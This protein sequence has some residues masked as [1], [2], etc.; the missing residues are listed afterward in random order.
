MVGYFEF[1]APKRVYTISSRMIETTTAE[2]SLKQAPMRTEPR[3]TRTNEK[4]E[5]VPR[6]FKSAFC[7]SEIGSRPK[8]QY[9]MMVEA[10]MLCVIIVGSCFPTTCRALFDQFSKWAPSRPPSFVF[11][12]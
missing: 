9:A 10:Y 2:S 1:E 4:I 3:G 7:S 6:R 12:K 11:S 5:V 8:E